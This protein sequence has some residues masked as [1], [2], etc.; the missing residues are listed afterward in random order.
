MMDITTRRQPAAFPAVIDR[1]DS[2]LVV[3]DHCR[4]MVEAAGFFAVPTF[5]TVE[6]LDR[7]ERGPRIVPPA[8][9]V[10]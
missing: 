9:T 3:I 8:G 7:I 2:I 5:V 6:V 10:L 1:E 4:F